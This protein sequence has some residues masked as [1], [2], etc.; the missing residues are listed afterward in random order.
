MLTPREQEIVACLRANHQ[1]CDIAKAL[2]L[3]EARVN[4]LV[5]QVTRKLTRAAQKFG[6]AE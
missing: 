4:Q 2:T 5:T 1:N 6:L 3:S